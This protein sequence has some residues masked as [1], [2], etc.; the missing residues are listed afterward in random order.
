MPI[1]GTPKIKNDVDVAE[2]ELKKQGIEIP[3]TKTTMEEIEVI[4]NAAENEGGNEGDLKDLGL[5]A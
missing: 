2:E 1:E 5:A 3:E 4:E